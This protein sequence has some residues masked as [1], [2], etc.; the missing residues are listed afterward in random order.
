MDESLSS[1]TSAA[2]L[3][4]LQDS[5][6]ADYHQVRNGT[7]FHLT[8]GQGHFLLDYQE[9]PAPVQKDRLRFFLGLESHRL[10]HHKAYFHQEPLDPDSLKD[11]AYHHHYQCH[12]V[13]VAH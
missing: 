3:H 1:G 6:V 10:D 2:Q 5:V 4:R 11:Q 8:E 7:Q 9:V 12:P 13:E